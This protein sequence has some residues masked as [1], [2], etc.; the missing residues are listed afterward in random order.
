MQINYT[1][2][3]SQGLHL[4][5][6]FTLSK[7]IDQSSGIEGHWIT[8]QVTPLKDSYNLAAERSL[9]QDDVPKNL[10]L[11]FIYELPVGRGKHW[12]K[13]MNKV[14][15]AVVGGWQVSGVTTFKTL[16]P[17]AM[18]AAVNNTGSLGGGQRPNIVGDP[19]IANPTIQK[20][21]NTAAFAQPAPYTFGNA[22]RTMPDVRAP[23][24]NN[25]DL[26]IQKWWNWGERLRIQFR[27]EMYNAFNHTNFGGPD[28]IF[29]SAT[30]GQVLS[31]REARSIQFGM[32][33]N[34]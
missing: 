30:F 21:F 19:H 3:W 15:N 16:F 1:H 2:R 28:R 34:W 10:V 27:A 24:F 18:V 13:N 7:W 11:S 12:G 17:I 5:A 33:V 9:H 20:W 32:K 25:A 4:L 6:S 31:A 8:A 14:L 23:G 22:P 26:N 29:G